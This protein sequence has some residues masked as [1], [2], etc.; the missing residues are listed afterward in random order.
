MPG[1]SPFWL[2]GN[3]E[4]QEVLRIGESQTPEYP[5]ASKRACCC[6]CPFHF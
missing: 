4:Q 5:D 3:T 6:M 2:G 1:H